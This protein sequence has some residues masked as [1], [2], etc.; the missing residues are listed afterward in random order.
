VKSFHVLFQPDGRTVDARRGDTLLDAARKA[1]IHVN[2]PCGG[3]GT[4][5]NCKVQLTAGKG[6]ALTEREREHFRTEELGQG[7]RLACQ[8]RVKSN[9]TC[10]IPDETRLSDQKILET[11]I[12]RTVPCEPTVT[13]RHLKL[14]PPRLPDQRADADRIMEALRGARGE[15]HI[16]LHTLRGLPPLL[17]NVDFNVT[18]VSFDGEL[19]S[20]E[21]G[22]TTSKSFGVAVDVG[23]TTVV[24]TLM[25]LTTAREL[26]VASRTNP[27]VAYGDDVVSRI[28]YAAGEKDGLALLHTRIVACINDIV[29][30]LSSRARV[31]STDVYEVLAVGNT[32]MMHLLLGVDP[33]AIAQAPY[34]A[35]YRQ[36]MSVPA[37]ELGLKICRCGILTVLPNVAGF[38]GA[39]TVAVAL[40]TEMHTSGELT[41]AVDIGTNGEIILGTRRKLIA[42]STAAGPAFEGARIKF[43][44]R[45][46]AGAIEAVDIDSDVRLRLISGDKVVGICGTGLIDTVAELLRVGIIEGSGRILDASGVAS[47]PEAVA[48][49]IRAGDH[50]NDFV[51]AWPHESQNGEPV[52]LTQRDV[53][54]VQLAKGAI[55]AG[56]Q[57]MKKELHVADDDIVRVLLAGAFGNYIRPERALRI[58]LLP[59]LPPERIHFVG[60]AASTGAKL[61]LVNRTCRSESDLLSRT[62]RYVELA[63][64]GDF[65]NEFSEA[66]LFPKK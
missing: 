3:T 65:Q 46:A 23:T 64:R 26:A 32:T 34:V 9:I 27:Q 17:R 41:L 28:A 22:D 18:V 63:G 62:I 29:H 31:H 52:Y 54:E 42:C 10:V 49:R 21:P 43:G 48:R 56:I 35:A 15:L 59:D 6:G 2:S 37:S 58:G 55:F 50:G 7:L 13:K 24:G 8:A 20:I 33:F 66:I 61:A 1:G 30:E 53:R 12:V 11:G 19:L 44:M 25:D 51:L 47:L 60:N 5:G 39:D 45:A 57:L 14:T 38:V 40:A 36:G 4:C 16:P